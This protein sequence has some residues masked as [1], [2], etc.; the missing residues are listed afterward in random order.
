MALKNPIYTEFDLNAT[1]GYSKIIS[2]T[3]TDDDNVD[4][5]ELCVKQ[6][7]APTD[8]TG[9]TA[10]ARMVLHGPP[11]VLISDNV[12]CTINGAGNILIPFDNASIESRKGI[13]KI[14]VN[15]TRSPDILTLQ[16]PLRVKINGS[17]LESATID[18]HSEGTIPELLK[19]VREELERVRGFAT[20]DD[21]FNVID[22]VF[23]AT[24]ADCPRLCVELYEG[25][26]WLTYYDS[27]EEVAHRIFNFADLPAGAQVQ[28]AVVNQNGTITFTNS[29]GTTFT[30]TGSSVIG[31]QGPAGADG[32]DYVLTAQDK[33]DIADIVLSE[34]PTTQGVLYG[35]TSN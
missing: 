12:A 30:T 5:I 24:G 17:I 18:P 31:P 26:Y 35:N 10:I 33:S 4:V 21:V 25:D 22:E 27:E 2:L 23:S 20:V 3:H 15:V 28:S 7:G 32:S 14:E 8:L 29:D 19:T 6:S 11:D 16:L 13:V 9:S 34:L 1:S